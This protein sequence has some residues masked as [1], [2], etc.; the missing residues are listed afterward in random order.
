[1]DVHWKLK[2]WTQRGIRNPRIDEWEHR[3]KQG[4]DNDVEMISGQP[5]IGGRQSQEENRKSVETKSKTSSD[6]VDQMGTEVAFL[7]REIERKHV[8]MDNC[9]VQRERP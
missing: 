5:S 8:R 6:K 9:A 4:C 2:R 1:V 7:G 3:R